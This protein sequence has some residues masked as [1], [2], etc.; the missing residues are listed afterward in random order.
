MARKRKHQKNAPSE[1]PKSKEVEPTSPVKTKRKKKNDKQYLAIEQPQ[2]NIVEDMIRTGD[3]I[4]DPESNDNPQA[5]TSELRRPVKPLPRNRDSEMEVQTT[6]KDKGKQKATEDNSETEDEELEI[7][8]IGLTMDSETIYGNK[9][10]HNLE[11]EIE[12]QPEIY[13]KDHMAPY[14]GLMSDLRDDTQAVKDE[15]ITRL[16]RRASNKKILVAASGK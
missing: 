16:F 14:R 13:F 10:S 1:D 15:E 9:I 2:L 12:D 5:S 4:L 3:M 8:F 11:T 7:K 6:S